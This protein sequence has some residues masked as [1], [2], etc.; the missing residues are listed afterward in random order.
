MQIFLPYPSFTES[1]KILDTKRLGNQRNEIYQIIKILYF[2]STGYMHHPIVKMW[3]GY[4]SSLILLYNETI[5]A[6]INRG[7]KNSMPLIDIRTVGK[8][9]IPDWFGQNEVHS[10]YRSLLLSKNFDYYS[11]LG[12]IESPN[13]EPFY[14]ISSRLQEWE[15]RRIKN[16]M[17]D[18]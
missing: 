9:L 13:E 4:E 8:I 1:S 2:K 18:R 7:Y 14:K 17:T 12:W 11:K 10:K 5:T 6:W 3:A 16:L 15:S